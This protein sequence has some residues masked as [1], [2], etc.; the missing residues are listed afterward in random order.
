VPVITNTD[1][2]DA[3]DAVL[4]LVLASAEQVQRV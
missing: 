1:M 2:R 3:I 4:E